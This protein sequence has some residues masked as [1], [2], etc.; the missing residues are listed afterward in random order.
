MLNYVF[1]HFLIALSNGSTDPL[2]DPSSFYP[3]PFQN[4]ILQELLSL[5]PNIPGQIQK[6]SGPIYHFPDTQGRAT[7]RSPIDSENVSPIL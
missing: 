6:E 7:S 3:E 1:G 5:N 4:A 2:Q